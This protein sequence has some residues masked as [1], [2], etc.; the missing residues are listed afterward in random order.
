[1]A[2]FLVILTVFMALTGL[3]TFIPA[4]K[5]LPLVTVVFFILLRAG[6]LALRKASQQ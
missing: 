3:S 4:E 1:M 2:R 6:Y 5:L